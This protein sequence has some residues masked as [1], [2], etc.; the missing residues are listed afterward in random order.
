MTRELVKQFAAGYGEST[1]PPSSKSSPLLTTARLAGLTLLSVLIAGYHPAAEDDSLYLAAI[2]HRLNPNLFRM[3]S[4]LFEVRIQATVFVKWIA[5]VTRITHLPLAW[6]E[7][8]FHLLTA[9]AILVACYRIASRCFEHEYARWCGVT[10]VAVMF[11]LPVTA[12]ALY[13][14]DEYLVPRAIATAFVLFAVD[15]AL[16]RRY[17]LAAVLCLAGFVFH[18][19]MAA[20]GMSLCCFLA[21]RRPML[22][23]AQPVVA[24]LASPLA[25][26]FDRRPVPAALHTAITMPNHNY[27]MLSRWAWYEWLGVV[28]PLF[29]LLWFAKVGQK[30]GGSE[31]K[32][33]AHLATRTVFYGAFQ[34][35]VALLIMLPPALE[36]MRPLEAMRYLHLLYFVMIL[37]AGGLA[38]EYLFKRHAWRWA[39]LFVPAALGMFL[40]QR[41]L[42][43]ATAHLELPGMRSSNPW[44]QSFEWIRNN[45][46]EDAYFAIG[47]DYTK[48]PAED[49]HGFRAVALRSAMADSAKDSGAVMT[50][51]E[52]AER[53]QREVQA[54]NAGHADWQHV[55]ADD[56]RKL[57]S[58]FGV[59][60]AVLQRPEPAGLAC[61]YQNDK[62]AVCRID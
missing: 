31:G 39:A 53:W 55:S 59:S 41:A 10:L 25:F 4:D 62:L 58:E 51:A 43:P 46:P 13:L 60:W 26:L 9:F 56:L 19:I 27:C 2:Q 48:Q 15:A 45:T 38:G 47:P 29:L 54:Q 42:F 5:F 17:G 49:T 6:V 28:V 52:L 30:D 33:L 8:T 34:L 11:T 57:K 7:L 1:L 44:M 32:V 36:R 40:A 22:N 12:T 21:I 24:G 35:A 23:R 3:D 50:S 20:F 37:L 14:M 61:P 18:P 16:G